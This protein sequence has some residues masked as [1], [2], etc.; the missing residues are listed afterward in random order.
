M[1]GLISFRECIA[2]P[3]KEGKKYWLRDH[4]LAVQEAVEK[5]LKGCTSPLAA[6]SVVVRL[7]G[8]AG[9]CHDVPKAH[10]EWQNY[11]QKKSRKG[12]S[13]APAGA[14]LFSYIGYHLLQKNTVWQQYSRIWLWLIRDIADHHGGLK[15]WN[16]QHWM[17]IAAWEKMDVAGIAEFIQQVYP[18]CS[19]LDISVK[20]L[21]Q[22][23]YDLYHVYHEAEDNA[24][25]V[26]ISVLE[27]MEQLS[28]W[29]ELTT[30]L[31]AGDRLHV[32]P[33]DYSS[34]TTTDYE[35][36]N[37][38]VTEFCQ[39]AADQSMADIRNAAQQQIL[40]QITSDP[41][42][43]M[44]TLEMPTGYGKTITALK[45]ATWLGK[46]QGYGKIVYVAPYLSI[47]EQTSRVMEN[48][49]R[50]L[51]LEHHSLAVLSKEDESEEV[52]DSQLV[53][54]AWGH[55]IVCTSFQQLAKAIFPGRA[56]DTLRRSY[57]HN[58]VVI[59]DEPQIFAT[60]SWNVF[61]YGLESLAKLYNLRIIFLSATMPPFEYGLSE[62]PKRLS[63]KPVTNVERYQVQQEG[64]M[65]EQQVADYLIS[66]DEM[67]QAVILNTIKDA[68]LV[69]EKVVGKVE[70]SNVKLL[71]G[72]MIPLHKRLEIEKIKHLLKRDTKDKLY[73]ISTQIIEAGVDLSFDHIMRALPLLPSIIQAAGRENRDFANPIGILTLML[74]LRNGEKNT[75]DSIYPTNLQ[76]ITDEL[77]KRKPVWKESELLDLITEY[78]KKMFAQNTYESSKR[79]IE[80]AYKGDWPKLGSFEVFGREYFKLP[81]F[82]PWK[83]QEE[84]T[85]F[86]PE[87]FSELRKRLR[88]V[89]AQNIYDRY[90]DRAYYAKLSFQERKEFM[91]LMNHYVVNV[92]EELAVSLVKKEAYKNGRIPCIE[93]KADYDPIAGL[94]NKVT[95]KY[96]PL[97]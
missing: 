13:H 18:E 61:L 41:L 27:Q 85:K 14:F 53:M 6:D 74:F 46:E 76:H 4:L 30:A 21:K 37:Q 28:V 83:E 51:P 79:N 77:L 16:E 60:E 69:Y 67:S 9:L 92:P 39:S 47:L 5:R 87:R 42:R 93:N 34:F 64:A 24:K 8:L 7:A 81:V 26:S 75:R 44:Y 89:S 80:D 88:I 22:W 86:L 50:I 36:Q 49:L 43:R 10:V 84:D 58:S 25:N 2:R 40:N 73:V 66:R 1:S 71:N 63:V 68:C 17:N 35:M 70:A 15:A 38:A 82:V 57:L 32:A 91:I 12:P 23:A 90:E 19:S 52:P 29:R 11:I 20:P 78:Y 72:M 33:M 45:I 65:D 96:D 97:T 31:I 62:E 94:A 59:I 3:D 48:A 55:P 95:A 56:Q 54:E